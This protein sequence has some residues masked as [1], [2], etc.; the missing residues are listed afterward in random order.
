MAIRHEISADGFGK[1][2]VITL[3]ARRAIVEF[4][5]EC[6]GFNSAEVRRCT[7][8]LCPLYPFRTRD[9]PEDAV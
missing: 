9:K 5:K 6:M 4:C 3:T 2:K 7:A 1:T 8:K